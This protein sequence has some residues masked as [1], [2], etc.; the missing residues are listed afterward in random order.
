MLTREDIFGR[1]MVNA[2][3]IDFSRRES[4]WMGGVEGVPRLGVARGHDKAGAFMRW[5]VDEKP[6]RDLDAALAVL[7]GTMSLEEA[8]PPPPEEPKP[9]PK[10]RISIDQQIEEV[11]YEL[12]QRASVYPRLVRKGSL[13]KGVADYH[14]RRMEAALETLRW[15]RDN[16][17]TIAQ[18]HKQ[19]KGNGHE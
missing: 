18:A 7:N 14:V 16:R 6:V 11:E 2:V 9:E 17:E 10:P 4:A 8:L 12:Q 5:Y 15:C 13:G 19:L 1:K 3:H